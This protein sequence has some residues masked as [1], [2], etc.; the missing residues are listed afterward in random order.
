MKEIE[1]M[2]C[3]DPKKTFVSTIDA[4]TAVEKNFLSVVT[5]TF[6]STQERDQ[7]IFQYTPIYS[8]NWLRGH[9]FARIVA[10]NTTF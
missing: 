7:A 9:F 2:K 4:D 5:H 3:L 6:L 10:M 8:N 1:K